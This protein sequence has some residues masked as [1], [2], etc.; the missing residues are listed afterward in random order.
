MSEEVLYSKDDVQIHGN[1]IVVR[2]TKLDY[3]RHQLGFERGVAPLFQK[4]REKGIDTIL[5]DLQEI[6]HVESLTLGSII[7]FKKEID[8]IGVGKIRLV[9]PSD[10][11][12]TILADQNLNRV[13]G[14]A[15]LTLEDALKDLQNP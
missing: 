4:C 15:Y 7:K 8:A 6:T 5:L 11:V 10:H 13:F 12:M 3:N 9:N 14:E 1:V 2:Y